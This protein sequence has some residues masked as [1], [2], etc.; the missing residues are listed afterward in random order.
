MPVLDW[1]EFPDVPFDGPKLPDR[2]VTQ[3]GAEV[4]G[5]WP[6]ATLRWWETVRRM[7]HCRDWSVTDW[8][9]GF[10]SAELHARLASGKG[11]FTELR[12]REA[13]MGMT[14]DARIGQRIRYVKPSQASKVE[15]DQG[16]VPA[17][18]ANVVTVDFGDMYGSAS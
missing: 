1:T 16:A 13:L 4:K 2:W 17:A 3:G 18:A 15:E 7:P 8:E 14:S 9:F 11:S 5:A 12:Q 10:G 6:R